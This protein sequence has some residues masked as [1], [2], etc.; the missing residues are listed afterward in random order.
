MYQVAFEKSKGIELKKNLKEIYN[1]SEDD[2]DKEKL[3]NIYFEMLKNKEDIRIYTIDSFTNRIF[4]QAIAPYFEISSFETLDSESNDFYEK[5]FK[6]I[7]DNE[8]YYK[9]FEFL[10][11][12][13]GEKKEIKNYVKI[14]E[15]LVEFQKKYVIVVQLIHLK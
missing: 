3:Q 13:V 7:M 8:N 11:E 2:F 14:I 10:I 12:E 5:I 1:L 9:K 15:E 4:K 6:K